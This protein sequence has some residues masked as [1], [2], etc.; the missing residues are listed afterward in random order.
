VYTSEGP[1]VMANC[2]LVV[3]GPARVVEVH[4]SRASQFRNCEFIVGQSKGPDQGP[5]YTWSALE[6]NG[7]G[8]V[9]VD[10]CVLTRPLA[11]NLTMELPKA[12]TPI[13]IS[14]S[15]LFGPA[16]MVRRRSRITA[17]DLDV[18]KSDRFQ[19]HLEENVLAG[20]LLNLYDG[21][22]AKEAFTRAEAQAFL[23]RLITWSEGHNAVSGASVPM[24]YYG[25]RGDS[26]P[27]ATLLRDAPTLADWQ[28][29]WKLERATGSRGRICFQAESLSEKVIEAPRTVSAADF[30]LRDDSLG[31]KAGP[32]GKDLGADVDRIG[33]GK[34]YEEWK[35]T[36]DYRAW[37]RQVEDLMAQQ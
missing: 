32:G 14:R 15:T 1:L 24:T 25:H 35:K 29:F 18:A 10:Q 23:R 6:C 37:R 21:P 19:I 3:A 16:L 12:G 4:N 27:R 8:G 22:G 17:A 13:R 2:R 11:I 20:P 9:V 36:D 28:Q 33:P 26:A 34:A 31:K 7:A 5:A 30:R